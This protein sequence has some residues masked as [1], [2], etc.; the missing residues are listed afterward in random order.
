MDSKTLKRA[1]KRIFGFAGQ[2][3]HVSESPNPILCLNFLKVRFGLAS[4]L[5]QLSA[6]TSFITCPVACIPCCLSCLSQSSLCVHLLWAF[7]TTIMHECRAQQASGWWY[8]VSEDKTHILISVKKKNKINSWSL[9]PYGTLLYASDLF[10]WESK[11]WVATWQKG[12]QGHQQGRSGEALENTTYCFFFSSSLQRSKIFLS[13]QILWVFKWIKH[14]MIIDQWDLK[15]CFYAEQQ[16]WNGN[17]L[18][19]TDLKHTCGHAKQSIWR[20]S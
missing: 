14:W 6:T 10:F 5:S 12:S 2:W 11:V 17:L 13:K 7:Y 18:L 16:I 8:P 1:R 9:H 3:N 4:N 15:Q 20:C 19:S